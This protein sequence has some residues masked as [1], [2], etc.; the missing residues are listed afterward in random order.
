L[1]SEKIAVKRRIGAMVSVGML[2][3]INMLLKQ[4]G[5][6]SQ[7]RT[8]WVDFF[9]LYNA[10]DFEELLAEYEMIFQA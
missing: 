1:V 10:S 5:L 9:K 8:G 2:C 4:I 7:R 3:R 6:R